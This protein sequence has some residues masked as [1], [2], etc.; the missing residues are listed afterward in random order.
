M[1]SSAAEAVREPRD[2]SRRLSSHSV[3][4]GWGLRRA[5]TS[6][7]EELMRLEAICFEEWRRDS[8]RMIRDSLR[9]PRH[10]VWVCPEV[11]S[12]GERLTATL[13]LRWLPGALRVY[14]LATD[15]ERQGSGM[16]RFLMD[17]ARRRAEESGVRAMRLEADAGRKGL[18][19][20]YERLGFTRETLLKDFYAPGRD[21][22]RMIAK[23]ADA[24]TALPE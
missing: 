6:D 22:W 7:L 5:E 15:P 23:L 12:G 2:A 10:E 13:V 17:F 11:E 19:G 1:K 20:W 24:P 18:L 4:L 8:R 21:A 16:G 9:N 3:G 14:S